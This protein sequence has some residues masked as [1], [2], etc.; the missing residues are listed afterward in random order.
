[1]PVGNSGRLRDYF[2]EVGLNQIEGH[3]RF[4]G[5][6]NNP[7]VDQGSV[8]E[9]AWADGG[10]YP[11]I[12]IGG[13]YLEIISDSAQDGPSGTGI[14]TFRFVLLDLLYNEVT[15]DV[16]L[17]GSTSTAVAISGGPYMRI[18]DGRKL[19]KGSAASEWRAT[20]I[21]NITIRDAGA[22]PT[23]AKIQSGRGALR[24][25]VY[26]IPN[27]YTGEVTSMLIGF[28]RGTGGGATRYVTASSFVQS[29]DGTCIYPID[30]SADGEMYRHDFMPGIF[31]AQKS[32]FAME[33]ISVSA[34]NSDITCAFQG[35]MKLNTTAI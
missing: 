8:P 20:N 33:I 4:V 35:I 10:I 31:L 27:G 34:D 23:R 12:P 18:N 13:K 26:T 21:G 28:N 24:Q 7:D 30:I 16:T 9:N 1:M 15:V 29:S 22:G 3:R 32:D 17:S 2:F 14:A 11:W 19:T 5:L 6:G 25:C